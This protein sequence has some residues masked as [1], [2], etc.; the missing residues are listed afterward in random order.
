MNFIQSI[1]MYDAV[2]ILLLVLGTLIGY[3]NGIIKKLV[4]TIGMIVVII[5]SY[6]LKGPVA[7][8]LYNTVPFFKFSGNLKGLSS[9]NILLYQAIAFFII[10]AILMI[11]YNIVL[12]LANVTE[13]VVEA[14]IVLSIPSKILGAIFGFIEMYLIIYIALIII[15]MPVFKLST[16]NESKVSNYILNNTPIV[17]K[18]SDKTLKSIKQINKEITKKETTTK[19]NEEITKILVDNKVI[20]KTTANKLIKENKI[21]GGYYD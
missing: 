6:A 20:D 18:V 19:M 5:L 1:N 8:I 10:F 7:N 13:K 2:I 14:T 9:L 15:S 12:K 4:S 21:I 17:S 3:Q 11:I 16:I